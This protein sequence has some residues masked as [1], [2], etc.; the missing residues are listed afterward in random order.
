MVLGES[1]GLGF[2]KSEMVENKVDITQ[3]LILPAEPD[4]VVF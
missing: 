4:I 2:V 3:G 1:F